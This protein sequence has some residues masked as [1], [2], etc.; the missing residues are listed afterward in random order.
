M[1]PTAAFPLR[2]VVLAASLLA[3]CD[4]TPAQAAAPARQPDWDTILGASQAKVPGP[5]AEVRWRDDLSR[6][7]AE[8]RETGRP[9]FVTLR[10]LPCKQCSGFDKN[11]LEGGDE[12]TP[13]LRQ[14]ITVRLT[15]AMALDLVRLPAAGYQDFDLSW[16]GYLLS[17]EAQLYGV[18][19]GRDE[20]SDT[21]RIS[22]AALRSTL[23]RVLQHHYDP[24]RRDWH[25]DGHPVPAAAPVL[26]PESLGGYERWR[27]LVPY[28]ARQTC[29]HCHQVGE[30][31]HA[32]SQVAGTFDKRAATRPWPLPENVGLT[33]DRDDGLLVTAVTADSAAAA[34]GLRGGD[35]LAVA[36]DRRLFG[37]ADFRGVLH[38][39]TDPAAIEVHWLR[40]GKR[41]VGTLRPT[42]DWRRTVL[43]WRMTISQGVLG[44]APGFFPLQAKAGPKDALAVTPFFG[45]DRDRSAAFRAGLRPHHILVAVNGNRERRFGR[46]FLTWFR[47]NLDRGDPVELTVLERGKERVIRFELPK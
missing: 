14:F 42:G 47:L 35:R 25:V 2:A 29:L 36:G 1:T 19:G 37:Q 40:G 24:R 46:A 34:I 43:D 26:S 17:P 45:R 32:T 38:R 9:V 20:V 31:L 8:A 15:D 23:Q 41:H 13:L 33:L 44:A 6:A 30:V 18:F 10:C 12:L 27:E 16:W 39:A 3:G 22:V 28:A 4:L 5:Q 21:T 7:L 11:V